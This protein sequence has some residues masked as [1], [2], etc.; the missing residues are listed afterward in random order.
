MSAV[1]PETVPRGAKSLMARE[2]IRA[3]MPRRDI[4][5]RLVAM[6]CTKN[7]AEVMFHKQARFI[8]AVREGALLIACDL[9]L[10]P[11][12]RAQLEAA[13]QAY[14]VARDTLVSQIIAAIV[15][16]DLYDAVLDGRLRR[17]P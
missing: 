12:Q 3:G 2:M 10:T 8:G 6:G 4:I 9:A 14:G 13:A 17:R 7:S 1:A 15:D 5:A 16:D 11:N